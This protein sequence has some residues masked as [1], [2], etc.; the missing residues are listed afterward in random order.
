MELSWWVW[1]RILYGIPLSITGIIYLVNPEGTVEALTSFLPG[2]YTLI[3][4]G[5]VL[6]LLLGLAAASGFK[7]RYASWGIIGLLCA[8]LVMIHVPA[9][10]AGEHLNIVWFELLR[11]LSL[12]GGAFF[13]MAVE[14]RGRKPLPRAQNLASAQNQS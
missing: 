13:M 8:Y 3:Y 4:V 1:G 7:P 2:G 10:T 14:G 11:N 6:W 5:G 12:M 9:A